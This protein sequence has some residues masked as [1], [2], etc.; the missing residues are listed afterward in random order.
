NTGGSF[1][2]YDET[3]ML[4]DIAAIQRL[5][6]A[7]DSTRMGDTIYGFNS[8]VEADSPYTITS[9]AQH[10][11][12]TIW[13]AG[14]ND[15]LDFSGYQQN[16]II[17]LGATT[18]SSVGGDI[19]N[20]SIAQGVSIENAIGGSGS[21]NIIGN[22]LDNTLDGG[23]GIDTAVFGG[24]YGDYLAKSYNGE[25][26]VLTAGNDG[27]DRLFNI[28]A[29]K[30]ADQT[31]S[32]QQVSGFDPYKYIAS[33]ADLTAVFHANGQAG[34]DHFIDFGYA[35]G[36]TATFDGLNYIASYPDLIASLGADSQ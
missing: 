36:R 25:I 6:G 13:D 31:I 16:Q 21:D 1:W 10:V 28:E 7:N 20:V 26:A 12:F 33:Y 30:F 8:N 22:G 14:G 2:V 17:N 4:H 29:L 32:A 15:T 27:H 5:Y 35:E 9:A 18:F 3:P 23:A 11:V 34:F 19:D 24:V